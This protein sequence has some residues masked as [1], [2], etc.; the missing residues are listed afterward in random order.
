MDID[1]ET[2]LTLLLGAGGA[3]FLSALFSGIRALQR[4]VASRTRE[5]IADLARWRDEANDA[6]ER[7]ERSRDAWRMYAAQLEYQILSSGGTI[8]PGVTRPED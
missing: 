7:A 6:R 2:L 3:G 4:G 8:P 5:G 1:V